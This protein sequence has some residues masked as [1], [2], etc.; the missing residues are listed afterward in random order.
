MGE[1]QWNTPNP[2]KRYLDSDDLHSINANFDRVHSSIEA[3]ADDVEAINSRLGNMEGDIQNIASDIR[4]LKKSIVKII[5]ILLQ[6][7]QNGKGLPT[8]G[9]SS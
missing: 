7:N 4:Y 8:N 5:N 9:S 6:S 1:S 3:L 2:N